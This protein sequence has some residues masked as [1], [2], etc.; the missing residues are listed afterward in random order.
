MDI[1]FIVIVTKYFKSMFLLDRN[2]IVIYR[3][4]FSNKTFLSLKICLLLQKNTG[5]YHDF[6]AKF[7]ED[8]SF[9]H[10]HDFAM[11]NARPKANFYKLSIKIFLTIS[12]S[13]PLPSFGILIEKL[14]KNY[15]I[16]QDLKRF[17]NLKLANAMHYQYEQV[18]IGEQKYRLAVFENKPVGKVRYLVL[19]DSEDASFDSGLQS[20][21]IHGGRMVALE[22]VE[23]RSLFNFAS[24]HETLIDPNRIF[25]KEDEIAPDEQDIYLFSQYILE[26]LNLSNDSLLVAL[27]N[28]SRYSSFGL[29]SIYDDDKMMVLCHYDFQPKNLFWFTQSLSTNF[30]KDK[31]W[32]QLCLYRG[33]NVVMENVGEHSDKSLSNFAHFAGIDYV[34]IEIKMGEKN[35]FHSEQEA[36]F[37]QQ[38]Y[39]NAL[40]ASFKHAQDKDTPI[41]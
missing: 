33:F 8:C 23:K 35:N 18:H 17:D 40:L 12:L 15:I 21:A 25:G 2:F 9:F 24:N 32:R 5:F 36:R 28:N 41:R 13:I 34:N 20:L 3:K 38:N 39:I 14:N 37:L 31:L 1:F 27:H 4:Q 6:L 10:Q 11:T 30:N 19:H 22:N 16:D 7:V 29:E 26:K